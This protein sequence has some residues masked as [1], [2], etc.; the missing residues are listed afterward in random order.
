MI[1]GLTGTFA[2]GKDTVLDYLKKKDFA[3]ISLSDVIRDEA[4]KQFRS[5]DRVELGVI[6]EEMRKEHG[7][8][9]LVQRALAS[10]RKSKKK[11]FVIGAIRNVEEVASLRMQPSFFLVAVDA[12][13]K[14][15][16]AR[17]K[18]RNREHYGSF[19]DFLAKEARE[20]S[21]NPFFMQLKECIADADYLIENVGTLQ[22]LHA[23]VDEVVK[24]ATR[25]EKLIS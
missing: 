2:S 23:K 4:K 19:D 15:R 5:L 1:L 12:P 10:L 8:D 16:F 17:E 14:V 18:D 13:P 9:V 6:A 3:A 20:S 11:N 7:K 24:D 25:Q 21:G 22:E